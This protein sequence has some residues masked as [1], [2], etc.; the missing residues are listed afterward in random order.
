[1]NLWMNELHTIF[2]ISFLHAK[3]MIIKYPFS[4]M[5]LTFSVCPP[6]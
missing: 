2:I 4:I 6:N 1:M 5:L 3:F